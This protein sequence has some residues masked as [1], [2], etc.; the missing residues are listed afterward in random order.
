MQTVDLDTALLETKKP[1]HQDEGVSDFTARLNSKIGL[2]VSENDAISRRFYYTVGEFN[3]LIEQNLKVETL[4]SVDIN[5]VPHAPD[6]CIGISSVRGVIMP[7]INVHT[8]LKTEGKV[9]SKRNFIMLEH[10]K[11]A[12]IIFQIDDLPSVADITEY[13]NKRRPKNTPK[14][15]SK[16]LSNNDN[17]LFEANHE[18]LLTQFSNN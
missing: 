11:Y 14:W 6:W 15:L 10:D 5:T 9:N 13:K 2:K 18:Q 8:I 16:Y 1:Q 7:V 4:Q 17:S 12:P 3:I